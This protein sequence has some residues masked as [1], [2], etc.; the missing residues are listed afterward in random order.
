MKR[1]L[2]W[3]AVAIITFFCG[4]VVGYDGSKRDTMKEAFEKGYA[5]PTHRKFGCVRYEWTDPKL[6]KDTPPEN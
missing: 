1:E 6:L 4:V 2:M 3:M 5:V